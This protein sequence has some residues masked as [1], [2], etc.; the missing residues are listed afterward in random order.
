MANSQQ[1]RAFEHSI[2]KQLDRLTHPE[3]AC[4]LA[5]SGG[6]DSVAMTHAVLRT[7]SAA[8]RNVSLVHVNHQLRK[9]ATDEAA[10]VETLANR[11]QIPCR[12]IAVDLA[13]SNA[14]SEDTARRAR[15]GVFLQVA[16]EQNASFVIT[17]HT[18]DDQT[19]TV[20]H[21][22]IR[23]TGLRGLAGIPATRQLDT[24][25]S[26][27]RPM[28]HVSRA[29][30]TNYLEA[31]GEPWCDDATNEQTDFTRNYI[32]NH[33]LPELRDRLNPQISDALQR[34]ATSAQE[35]SD[36]M[37]HLV[38]ARLSQLNL[39]QQSIPLPLFA[40]CPPVLIAETL[41]EYW[42]RQSWPEQGMTRRHWE[43][44]VDLVTTNK[45]NREIHLPGPI[46][47]KRTRHSLNFT[48]PTTPT[49]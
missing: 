13:G 33:L 3:K 40:D 9:E 5:V 24:N 39:N 2:R 15:H 23:G 47:A 34:L 17:A 6:R 43:S 20:L 42:R 32:R 16:Q 30:V 1:I 49:T 4:I 26:L 12:V 22:I 27:V 8:P 10:F 14:I 48:P 29:E 31:I 41:R 36:L 45:S 18:A 28:L 44:L 46:I 7:A 25:I 19:E 21:R 38:D 35:S 37:R 11:L